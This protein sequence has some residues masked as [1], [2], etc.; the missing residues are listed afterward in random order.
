MDVGARR[1][2]YAVIQDLVKNGK[3][4]LLISSDW[5]ELIALSDRIVVLHEGKVKGEL[6]GSE[7][8]PENILQRA[9][10]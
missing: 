2:I 3:S 4:V 10:A 8:N 1:E 6:A 7:A 5:S 9:L